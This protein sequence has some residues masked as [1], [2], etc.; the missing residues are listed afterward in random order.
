M[1]MDCL[2][3]L[4][5]SLDRKEPVEADVLRQAVDHELLA[6]PGPGKRTRLDALRAALP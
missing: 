3:Y 5:W 6:A 4:Q 1:A 2:R